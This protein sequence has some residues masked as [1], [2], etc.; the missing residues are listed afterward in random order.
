MSNTRAALRRLNKNKTY[1]DGLNDGITVAT[2]LMF[3]ALHDKYGF[4]SLKSGK[5]KLDQIVDELASEYAKM[6]EDATQLNV[7]HYI[8]MLKTSTGL[9]MIVKGGD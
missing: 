7:Q 8:D 5:G 1:T 4:S 3:V 6:E 9:E 2:A